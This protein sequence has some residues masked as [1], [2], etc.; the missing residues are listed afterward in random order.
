MTDI[1][2]GATGADAEAVRWLSEHT[3]TGPVPP[4]RPVYDQA[5]ALVCTPRS[6]DKPTSDVE[7]AW[8]ARRA[9]LV[10]Y[11]DALQRTGTVSLTDLLPDLLHLHHARV[12]GPDL[13]AERV[14][15]HLARAA[16][17]S[18]LARAGRAS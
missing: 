11:R 5:V 16:G 13:D 1:V 12:T 9:A 15:L 10:V 14:C 6:A 7:R 4:P 18:W 8:T 2:R 17:Q 3:R